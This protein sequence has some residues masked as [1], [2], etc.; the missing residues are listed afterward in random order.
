MKMIITKAAG[1]SIILVSGLSVSGCLM[2][3]TVTDSSGQVIYQK[4]VV[5]NPF[6]SEQK[7]E[8]EVEERERELGW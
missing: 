1:L 5:E 6:E 8:Q 7:K 3:Q 4:P 2:E